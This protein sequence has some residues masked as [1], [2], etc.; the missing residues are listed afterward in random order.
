[1]TVPYETD[2]LVNAWLKQ[3]MALPLISKGLINDAVQLLKDTIPSNDN[4]YHKFIK[5]FEKE[6]MNRTSN[7]LWHHGS[8]DMKTNNSLEGNCFDYIYQYLSMDIF[9]PFVQGTIFDYLLGLD[10]IHQ[11]GNSYIF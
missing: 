4:R 6:Y 9:L 5:Y 11:Y 3:F 1:L 2:P 8:N 10:Y 7:D